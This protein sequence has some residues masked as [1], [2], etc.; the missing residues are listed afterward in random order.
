M[1]KIILVV[2]TFITV[3][4]IAFAAS[5]Y[6]YHYV[7]STRCNGC[8]QY[9]TIEVDRNDDVSARANFSN[10]SADCK[11]KGNSSNSSSI[12]SKSKNE[13]EKCN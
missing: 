7:L 1:K 6:K 11:F 9:Q 5:C 3:V 13:Y 8:H 10:H 4:G 2:A 12:T